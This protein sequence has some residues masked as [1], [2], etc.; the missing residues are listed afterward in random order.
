MAIPS[1]IAVTLMRNYELTNCCLVI[2]VNNFFFLSLINPAETFT[3]DRN[4]LYGQLN[5]KHI[6]VPLTK[7][8]LYDSLTQPKVPAHSVSKI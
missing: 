3:M 2:Y 4:E 7:N 6:L 8:Q 1:A 5:G